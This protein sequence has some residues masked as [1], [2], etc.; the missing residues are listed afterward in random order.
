MWRSGCSMKSK[1][2][3]GVRGHQHAIAELVE[4]F[5]GVA[6]DALV[7]LD[8]QDRFAGA[9]VRPR[10]GRRLGVGGV[11]EAARQVD[12]DGAAVPFSL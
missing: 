10:L 2:V 12:L 6:A 5:A 8:D 11:R 1:G 9:S 7:V 4:D 3:L